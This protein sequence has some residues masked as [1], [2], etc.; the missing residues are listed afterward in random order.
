MVKLCSVHNP[1]RMLSL[2]LKFPMS[3]FSSCW[4]PYLTERWTVQSWKQVKGRR[5]MTHKPIMCHDTECPMFGT[6]YDLNECEANRLTK[7][8]LDE[9]GM[10]SLNITAVSKVSDEVSGKTVVAKK[11]RQY[12]PGVDIALPQRYYIECAREF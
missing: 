9:T 2:E 3:G 10:L 7:S 12:R 8:R 6:P 1:K 11:A 5:V 4:S